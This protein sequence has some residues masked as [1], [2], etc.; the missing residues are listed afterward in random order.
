[1]DLAVHEVP[2]Y[3]AIRNLVASRFSEKVDVDLSKRAKMNSTLYFAAAGL[4]IFI[5]CV[6]AGRKIHRHI[7]KPK[8]FATIV[9]I[10]LLTLLLIWLLLIALSRKDVEPP[11]QPAD[12][13]ATSGSG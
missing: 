10:S 11:R 4:L 5:A 9:A 2:H 7:M 13:S 8:L 6:G 3:P 1:M 12:Y